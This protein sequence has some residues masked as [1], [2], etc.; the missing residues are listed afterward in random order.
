MDAAGA[1]ESLGDAVGSVL[2]DREAESQHASSLG[3]S[4][5]GSIFGSHNRRRRII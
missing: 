2:L 4:R 3:T 1:L 5:D